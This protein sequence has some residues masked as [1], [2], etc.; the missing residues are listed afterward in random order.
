MLAR[1]DLIRAAY[2]AFN[3]RDLET[4]LAGLHPH[5]DWPNAIDGGRVRGHAQVRAY[6]TRQ[7]K[8]IDP[9]VEPQG[10]SED[11]QGQIVVDVHQ[12]VRDLDGGVIADQYL[13]HLYTIKAGLIARMDI[14]EH[15]DRNDRTTMR[16]QGDP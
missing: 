13:Q 14:R 7:F 3:A 8:T 12:V 4:A 16:R 10:F 9:R 2:A 11:H 15:P 5:V 6:W 1:H